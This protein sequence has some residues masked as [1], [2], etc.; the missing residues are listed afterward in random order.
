M[1]LSYGLRHIL[2][3][4]AMEIDPRHDS[5]SYLACL[6]MQ[7]LRAK[8]DHSGRPSGNLLYACSVLIPFHAGLPLLMPLRRPMDCETT[9]L[10]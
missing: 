2:I 5:T 8:H 6:Q 3:S 1:F 9:Y 7:R 10:P 4:C